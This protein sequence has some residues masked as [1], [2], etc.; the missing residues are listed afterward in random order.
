ML[1]WG[2]ESG[3]QEVCAYREVHAWNS[4]SVLET[5]SNTVRNAGPRA[6]KMVGRKLLRCGACG[7]ELYLNVAAAVA[8]VIVDE[9]GRM[10]VL[11]RGKEPGQGKWDLP[12]GFVDP[13]ETAEEALRREV[14]EEIGLE[15]TSLSYLGQWP[16]VYEYAG[17]PVSDVG[18]GIRVPDARSSTS[19]VEGGRDCGSS[20]PADLRR[21]RS[22][23]SPSG[24]WGRLPGTYLERGRSR[25]AGG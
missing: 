24:P 2:V 15:V 8:G 13:E 16:N 1:E 7:F 3:V 4:I 17:V 6:L 21:L 11:V 10:V 9:Q 5:C 18:P 20:V 12:G 19:P 25:P 23:G 22:G 14:R